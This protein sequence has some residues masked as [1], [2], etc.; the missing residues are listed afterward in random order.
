MVFSSHIFI[1]W[2][3]P[4]CLISYMLVPKKAK[5]SLVLFF[6]LVFY[7]WGAPRFVLIL[8]GSSLVDFYL[9]KGMVNNY[10]S[11]LLISIGVTLNVA[12]LATFK[13]LNF[14]IENVN[15]MLMQ[16]GIEEVSWTSV[17]LPI[18]ISFFTFQKISYLVDV[19]RGTC[20]PRQSF[21]N[22]LL[23]VSLFPQLIAGPIVRYK[24]VADQI[25]DRFASEN[26]R[27][28]FNGI[29]RFV[30]GLA[31]KVLIANVLAEQVDN[32]FAESNISD[33]GTISVWIGMLAYSFQIYFD[34][35]GY[36]DMAI[37]LGKMIGFT[38]PENFNYPYISKN[39]TE[40]WRRWHM[41]LGTW[42][43]DYLYI[44]L[45]GNRS[46]VKR[47]YINLWTVFF[48]SGIWHGA[49]WNFMLWGIFHG[50][51]LILDRLFLIRLTSKL[52]SVVQV[53]ITYFLTLIGWVLFRFENAADFKLIYS[54]MFSWQL[55]TTPL[56]PS[57]RFYAILILAALFA[58]MGM[59][60]KVET[61]TNGLY[62]PSLGPGTTIFKS[63][64]LILIFILCVSELTV[65]GYNPFI[66]FK[67]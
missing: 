24:D 42:M 26:A 32:M 14:F 40:F 38:F 18:G 11:K 1:F 21:I 49:S 23:F 4:L 48:I 62:Q 31:K 45:G 28:R 58:F 59:R 54:R 60:K 61:A 29:F 19:Y 9:A 37:G 35:S 64:T 43:K 17:A 36:S 63:L 7:A 46:S 65:S 2:F 50:S 15:F 56:E 20:R 67:F 44:P 53:L 39:I 34:F 57:N 41:T 22:Y 25:T 8:I 30:I 66:Y 55:D 33:L 13:Y 12:L 51:I 47:T 16:F 10:R 5:N 3:L 27:E 52:H 6:S